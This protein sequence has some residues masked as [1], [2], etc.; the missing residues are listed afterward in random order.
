MFTTPGNV[1]F[2][3][4]AGAGTGV[5]GA[6]LGT[7][8]GVFLIPI[9]LLGFGVDM[10]FAVATSIVTVIATSSAVARRNHRRTDSCQTPAPVH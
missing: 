3:F 5:M 4:A 7:G 8:G 2:L 6:I 9:L 10:H 1:A